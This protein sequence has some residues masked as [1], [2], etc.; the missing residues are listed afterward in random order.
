MNRGHTNKLLDLLR[1]VIDDRQRLALFE[2]VEKAL[3]ETEDNIAMR[4][5]AGL[6]GANLAGAMDK[7]DRRAAD[8][9]VQEAFFRHSIRTFPESPIAARSLGYKLEQRGQEL[10]AMEIYREG[11]ARSPERLDLRLLLA[12]C[13]SPFLD[14]GEQSDMR[15]MQ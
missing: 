3:I 6:L 2:D 11:L 5:A 14:D 8:P 1:L 12:S 7:Y 10:H 4:E 13:C 9:A 15:Y